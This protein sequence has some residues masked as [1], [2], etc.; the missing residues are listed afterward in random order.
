MGALTGAVRCFK[1]LLMNVLDGS[2][3]A[4]ETLYELAYELHS[5]GLYQEA[6]GRFDRLIELYSDEDDMAVAT[7]VAT[8]AV[9]RCWCRWQVGDAKRFLAEADQLVVD[10]GSARD[11]WLRTFAADGLR[12]KASW[13]LRAGGSDDAIA[14]MHELSSLFATEQDADARRWLGKSLLESAIELSWLGSNLRSAAIVEL[15]AQSVIG[16]IASRCRSALLATPTPAGLAGRLATGVGERRRLAA[17]EATRRR[18]EASLAIYDLLIDACDDAPD[19]P[20]HNLAI[21][22]RINRMAVLAA[23]GRWRAS[24]HAFNDLWARDPHEIATAIDTE[25]IERNGAPSGTAVA[26]AI[27]LNGSAEDDESS[28]AIARD[29]LRL[30]ANGPNTAL[31][32]FARV[33][34]RIYP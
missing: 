24:H 31:Q 29:T 32:R 1:L 11:P 5:A 22:A 10:Y 27:L 4:F 3:P 28:R 23:L 20:S 15:V 19:Q 8:A 30:A 34:R 12:L 13:I 14:I 18:L 7:A 25:S 33:G 21:R 2:D 16:S 9:S 6:I 17:V 26:L